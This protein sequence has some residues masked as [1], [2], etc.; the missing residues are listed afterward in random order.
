[1]EARVVKKWACGYEDGCSGWWQCLRGSE[2][3]Q[4]NRKK[5]G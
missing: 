4:A 5:H 1:M 2:S 3:V